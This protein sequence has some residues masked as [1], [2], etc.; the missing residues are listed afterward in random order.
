MNWDFSENNRDYEAQLYRLLS[1]I[2]KRPGMWLGTPS[3]TRLFLFL[4]G[5]T[6][7][8]LEHEGYRLHFMTDFLDYI[9]RVYPSDLALNWDGL[10]LMGR[11]EEEAL[12]EFF[13]QL[14]LFLE[15]QAHEHRSEPFE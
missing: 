15:T 9:K 6:Y 14:D 11:T 5:Y 7:A 8:V 13:R 12:R 2:R 3:I 10:L 4:H 1:Q